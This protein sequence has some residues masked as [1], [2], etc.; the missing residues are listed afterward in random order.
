MAMPLV[1]LVIKA[2]RTGRPL[3]RW[4]VLL[5]VAVAIGIALQVPT[6]LGLL[7]RLIAG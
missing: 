7:G 1:G 5:L 2:N 3:P 4:V 6:V